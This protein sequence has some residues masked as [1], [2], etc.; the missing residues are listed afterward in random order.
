M[1]KEI[2]A[3]LKIAQDYLEEFSVPVFQEFLPYGIYNIFDNGM[4]VVLPYPKDENGK[5]IE[6]MFYYDR[7]DIHLN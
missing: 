2:R 6:Q 3:S 5:L 4:H 1:T 7:V